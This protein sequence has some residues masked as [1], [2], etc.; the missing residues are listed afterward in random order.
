MQKLARRPLV[1][2]LAAALGG[3]PEWPSRMPRPHSIRT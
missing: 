1:L 2:V 3:A